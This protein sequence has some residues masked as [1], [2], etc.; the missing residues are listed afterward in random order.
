MK[1]NLENRDVL[2]IFVNYLGKDIFVNTYGITIEQFDL[3]FITAAYYERAE[4]FAP[5]GTINVSLIECSVILKELSHITK[6]DIQTVAD[7]LETDF[8]NI[9]ATIGLIRFGL[10]EE[11]PFTL[12]RELSRLGY[13]VP[14]FGKSLFSLGIAI[15]EE[16]IKNIIEKADKKD[17]DIIKRVQSAETET[18]N[19]DPW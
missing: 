1:Q 12:I 7:I 19:P 6:E 3:D 17:E 8:N 13:A 16:D 14:Y 2:G 9:K 10:E 15:K 18:A 5:E 11:V 4:I